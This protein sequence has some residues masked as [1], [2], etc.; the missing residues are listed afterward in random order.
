MLNPC[1]SGE[2]VTGTMNGMVELTYGRLIPAKVESH[3]KT[4]YTL[5]IAGD[6]KHT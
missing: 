5:L 4:R 3:Q 6:K 1:T 2:S